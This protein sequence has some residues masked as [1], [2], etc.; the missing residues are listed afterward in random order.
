MRKIKNRNRTGWCR[1]DDLGLYSGGAWF[2]S[3]PGHYLS[4]LRFFRALPQSLHANVGTVLRL[5]HDAS[6]QIFY[7][8][9]FIY[10]HK[11]RRYTVSIL[12][13]RR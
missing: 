1:G 4:W 5:G 7:N 9:L 10:R 13:R 12:K 6:F 11:I 2:E 8:S 3:R